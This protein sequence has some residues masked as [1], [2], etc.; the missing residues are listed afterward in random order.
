[1]ANKYSLQIIKVQ[2]QEDKQT[3]SLPLKLI[4]YQRTL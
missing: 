1:M 2:L 3:E 4:I